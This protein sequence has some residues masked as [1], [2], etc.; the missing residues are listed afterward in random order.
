MIAQPLLQP[1]ANEYCFVVTQL[2]ESASACSSTVSVAFSGL[3]G[4]YTTVLT[5]RLG[6]SLDTYTR[7]ASHA[8]QIV[9]ELFPSIAMSHFGR[10][11]A[12]IPVV[13]AFVS[14]ERSAT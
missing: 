13:S 1:L 3:S 4:G 8:A 2:E 11:C 5:V 12:S 14:R 6:P 9:T 10:R 7:A